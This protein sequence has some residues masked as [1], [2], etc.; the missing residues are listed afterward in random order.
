M[1]KPS[2]LEAEFVTTYIRVNGVNRE[3]FD[4]F[5]KFQY[6]GAV[7]GRKFAYDYGAFWGKTLVEIEGGTKM[8][9]GGHNTASGIERDCEKG[10]LAGMAGF[11]LFRL[12]SDML[13]EPKWYEMIHDRALRRA[14]KSAGWDTT[15]D[16]GVRVLADNWADVLDSLKIPF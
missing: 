3:W 9:K 8:A 14:Y 13:R 12:T 5:W 2:D 4:S 6:L 15:D 11:Q 7:P 16:F 1:P 10:N